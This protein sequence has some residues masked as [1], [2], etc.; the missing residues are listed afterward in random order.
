VRIEDTNG[1]ISLRM[2]KLGSIQVENRKG[3]LQIYLPDK[4]SFQLDARARGGEFE[5][6]FPELKVNNGDEQSSASGSVG[7]GGPHIVLNNEHGTIEL[8]KGSAVAE[9]PEPPM[10]PKAP[11]APSAPKSKPLEPTEN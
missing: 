11:R 7:T 8:R 10:P 5:T 3:D 4:S 6:D 2:A 9:A 1:D